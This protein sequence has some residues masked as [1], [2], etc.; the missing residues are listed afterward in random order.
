MAELASL[1]LENKPWPGGTHSLHYHYLALSEPGPSLPEFLA[2]G[3]VDD[4]PFIRYDSRT[5]RAEL[6]AAWMAPVDTQYWETETQKQKA[7]EKVQQVEMWTVMGYHNQSSEPPMVHITKHM[8][9]DGT[10]LRCWALGF[11][12]QDISLNWWLDGEELTLET[13]HV[14][15][16]PSGDGTYQTW[17]AVQVPAGKEAWYSCHVRHP[18]LN[19]TLTVAWESPSNSGLIAMAIS[20]VLIT[21]MLI[22]VTVI[23]SKRCLQAWNKKSY[24]QTPGQDPESQCPVTAG[25]PQSSLLTEIPF[26]T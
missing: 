19:H 10:T 1:K 25:T 23:W 14:E 2:V 6:R 17:V 12:P 5:G 16:R 4:Q 3:Y 13:E 8:T 7:W 9:Q 18:G 22:A 15:T 26:T 21:I 20:T 11:Y 24:V